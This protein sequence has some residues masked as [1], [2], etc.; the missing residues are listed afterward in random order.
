MLSNHPILILVVSSFL[1]VKEIQ[2]DE[3]Q[4]TCSICL[5]IG[6]WC[7]RYVFK[8]EFTIHMQHS[9]RDNIQYDKMNPNEM[10]MYLVAMRS[11]VKQIKY[12]KCTY[13]YHE[14]KSWF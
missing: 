4:F 3:C 12:I 10:M 6:K 9:T 1:H 11:I 8:D 7:I 13:V 14:L 2:W 5:R